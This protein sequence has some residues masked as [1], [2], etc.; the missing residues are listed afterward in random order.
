MAA[1]ILAL[2]FPLK[3]KFVTHLPSDKDIRAKTGFIHLKGLLNTIVNFPK[4][5]DPTFKS[6]HSSLNAFSNPSW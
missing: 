2:K 3:N 1:F 5:F 4:T 6:Q